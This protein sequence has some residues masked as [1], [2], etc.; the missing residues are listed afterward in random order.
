M[1][2]FSSIKKS[3]TYRLALTERE[4]QIVA[5]GN[6]DIGADLSRDGQEN[7]EKNRT[8]YGEDPK[9][10]TGCHHGFK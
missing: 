10:Q 7:N 9:P 8:G 6:W 5:S 1:P 4:C 2:Y 3:V